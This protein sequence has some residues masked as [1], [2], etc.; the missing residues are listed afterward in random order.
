MCKPFTCVEFII[1]AKNVNFGEVEQIFWTKYRI[2]FLQ[3]LT[4]HYKPQQL[5]PQATRQLGFAPDWAFLICP[6]AVAATKYRCVAPFPP[7]LFFF[8][9]ENCTWVKLQQH[10]VTECNMI[11]KQ[12]RQVEV[13]QVCS[14]SYISDF[15]LI[16]SICQTGVW[17]PRPK[18]V[19]QNFCR[20]FS[21]KWAIYL[22]WD[23]YTEFDA[24]QYV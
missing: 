14:D 11:F 9:P 3:V 15:L 2:T 22:R 18:F 17:Q 21:S 16:L 10:I 20:F 24:A 5:L 1:S 23:S 8:C 7:S 19:N 12:K 13:R 6:P 4:L